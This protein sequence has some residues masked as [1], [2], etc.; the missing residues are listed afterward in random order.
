MIVPVRNGRSDLLRLLDCLVGQTVVRERF[1]VVIGDDGSTD[2]STEGLATAHGWVTVAPGPPRNS[3]AARNR[4][5]KAARA[6]VL[7]FCD[8]D[9]LPEPEWLAAGLA[10]LEGADLAAGLI[11]YV[12]PE[13]PTV[14]TLLDLENK[15]HELQLAMGNA[16]TA[17][18]FVRRELFEQLGGFDDTLP[19]HGDFDFVARARSCATS[20]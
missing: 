5:A 15:D 1:E 17:N 4:A 10:A 2:G 9:C 14:W 8:A 11:R 3:Y 16:E 13:R 19:E 7:A 20:G 6:P 12:V 18:L